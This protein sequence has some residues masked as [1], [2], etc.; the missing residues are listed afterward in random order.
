MYPPI[1]HARS[2]RSARP[3]LSPTAAAAAASAVP[4]LV[5]DDSAELVPLHVEV[6]LHDQLAPLKVVP[7]HLLDCLFGVV[8]ALKLE[9][10]ASPGLALLVLEE[11]DVADRPDLLLE[12]VLHVLPLGLERYVRDEHAFLGRGLARCA[13]WRT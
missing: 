7:V 8:R 10:A 13:T 3:V 5:G 12:H 11:V 9:D 4:T 2:A 1:V 6:L